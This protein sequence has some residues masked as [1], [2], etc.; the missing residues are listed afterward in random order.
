MHHILPFLLLLLLLLLSSVQVH[1]K[2]AEV[3]TATEP[4]SFLLQDITD[5]LCLS[6]AT[7][8]RCAIDSLLYVTGPP[9][10][11][12]IHLRPADEG[13]KEVCLAR[14]TCNEKGVAKTEDLKVTK[15]THCGATKWNILGGPEE[16]YILSR[17]DGKSCLMREAGTDKAVTVPCR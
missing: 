12:A 15:C 11:Y 16:G 9:G 1:S 6:G 8:K 14:K 10:D 2:G 7:F 13:G 4:P 5:G 3:V 17:D